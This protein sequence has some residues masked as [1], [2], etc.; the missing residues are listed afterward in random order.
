MDLSLDPARE[1]FRVEV[2]DWLVANVPAGPL[3]SLDT[4]EGFEAHREWERRLFDARLAVVTWPENYG[5]RGAD[6]L[7]WLA[8]EEEYWAAGAPVRVGQNGIFLLAPTMWE[9]A[10]EAQQDRFMLRMARGDDIWAQGWS[11]PGAGSDL[12]A[13]RSRADRDDGRG[14]WRVNGQKTWST[15][16]AYADWMF[17]LFRTDP[18]STRHHGLTYLLLP[19]DADG[20]TVRPIRQLDGEP[21]FAEVFFDDVFV[22][23]DQ[24]LGEVGQGWRVAMSTTTSERGL[25]LRSPGRFMAAADRLVDLARRTPDADPMLV[26]DAAQAWLDADAYRLYVQ[27]T[28]LEMLAGKPVGAESSANKLFWSQLDVRIHE[29][30]LRLLGGR[31]TF[32]DGPDAAWLDGYL[33][34]LAGPIYAG[35]NEVQRNV[36]AERVLGLPR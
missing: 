27:S 18:E 2:R 22:P 6:V 10:T 16:A 29:T 30:A 33:F 25:T 8:F 20:V 7:D 31:A 36:V 12:A 17:G 4:R 35:T 23:D 21:G 26:A 1:E 11:E 19:L 34:S 14:G 28:A 32:T 3:P 5:G 9:F 24:V 15:R 13:L